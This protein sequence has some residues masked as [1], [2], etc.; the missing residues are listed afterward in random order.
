MKT[1]LPV[2]VFTL[3]LCAAAVPLPAQV[4]TVSTSPA[5][6][7]EIAS[8]VSNWSAHQHLW[9]RG[10]LGASSA[11]LNELEAWLDEKAPNWTIVLLK[12]AEGQTWE[13]RRG[14]DAVEHALGQGLSNATDF[15]KLADSRTGEQNGAVF[16]LFLEERKF[17]YFASEAF[18]NRNL[19]EDRWVGGLDGAAISAMRQGGRI[20]DAV[21]DTV[22]SIEQGLTTAIAREAENRRLAQIQ[23]RQAIAEATALPSQLL[24]SI[25]EAEKRAAQLREGRAGLV[26]PLVQP[27]LA[28]WRANAAAVRELATESTYPQALDLGRT[29]RE[30]IARFHEGIDQ[31]KV[32]PAR[33]VELDQIIAELEVPEGLPTV[34]GHH[35]TAREALASARANHDKGDPL[36]LEQLERTEQSIDQVRSGIERWRLTVAEAQRRERVRHALFTALALVALLTFV[37]V[38]IVAN[39]RRR[40]HKAA[41]E[42][43]YRDW[44]EQLRGKFDRLFALMDQASLL[45]GSSTALEARGF[46][47]TTDTLARETIRGVDE[48]FIMSAATD[49]VMAKAAALIDPPSPLADLVNAF[50]SKRYREAI[51]L[52][53]SQPIGFDRSDQLEAILAPVAGE[54]SARR[55]LL[56]DTGDYEPF[57]LSFE[58]LIHEYEQRE[59][60]VG[61]HLERLEA[62]IAALPLLL[63]SLEGA[64]AAAT[65]SAE[66]LHESSAVDG[67]FPLDACRDTLLPEI[68]RQLSDALALG[69]TDPVTAR[70]GSGELARRQLEEAQAILSGIESLRSDDFPVVRASVDRLEGE[71]RNTLW[72]DREYDALT[73]RCESLATDAVSRP[74]AAD[75]TAFEGDLAA[76]RDRI[77]HSARLAVRCSA[78]CEPL[79]TQRSE[80]VAAAKRRIAAILSLPPANVLEEPDLS[81]GRRIDL[82]RQQLAAARA[83]LDHGN[84]TAAN[85]DLAEMEQSLVETDELLSLSEASLAGHETRHAGLEA[86]HTELLAAVPGVATLLDELKTGYEEAVLFFSTRFRKKVT[87]Q[88]SVRDSIDLAVKA[89]LSA[90]T[91]LDDAA[92]TFRQGGLIAASRLLESAENELNAARHQLE[93]VRDHHTA[94]RTAETDNPGHLDRLVGELAD[95]SPGLQDRRTVQTTIETA[96]ELRAA[97][98]SL[99]EALVKAHPNPF[100]I[101]HDLTDHTGVLHLIRDGIEADH[102]QHG[103]AVTT[104]ARAR[105]ALASSEDWIT[106]ARTDGITDSRALTEALRHHE[107]LTE[108]WQGQS[109]LLAHD[110]SPWSR[111]CET[112]NHLS[113]RALTLLGLIKDEVLSAEAAALKINE[114]NQAAL[115][116]QTWRSS[117][118]VYLDRTVGRTGLDEAARFLGDGFYAEAIQ[119]GTQALALALA[120]KARVLTIESEQQRAAAAARAAQLRASQATAR[121]NFS[122]SS[123]SS[124]SSSRS[125]SSSGFSRSSSSSGSG[126]SRS[127]W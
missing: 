45:V 25:A 99:Q 121:R 47:G 71:R 24:A 7:D 77:E 60:L 30:A 37:I 31:W 117:H 16:V 8:V 118:S 28:A 84:A 82:A 100:H 112:G 61:N 83:A 67:W 54:D 43:L 126:F 39:R 89:S 119:A 109:D 92:G 65:E 44:K 22:V 50:H 80:A 116:L 110:H 49:R 52:L 17:S 38:L 66:A 32:A 13:N 53:G 1:H 70:E 34:A 115:W 106:R 87:G 86:N 5:T 125:S 108:L 19:G 20:V 3:L 9:I 72:I 79:I 127:G 122:S 73:V 55:S 88:Q 97:L 64:V 102:Q 78:E 91:D 76:L 6:F 93:L 10:D 14:M 29:T 21:R 59:S 123:S 94:L 57:R 107:E 27:D 81:P 56:G 12:N 36:F 41:A 48:L 42:T 98:A 35:A 4:T 105:A 63:Q 124:S 74:I 75:W 58:Q 96:D 11:K 69:K 120:E 26:G 85:E 111:I 51:A 68:G 113:T 62:G 46:S 18:D 95:L 103:E 2:S 114:A 104:V 90:K 15:S 23:R 101:Y 40:P 33:F